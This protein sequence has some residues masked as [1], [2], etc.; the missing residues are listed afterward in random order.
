MDAVM[1]NIHNG[2]NRYHHPTTTPFHFCIWPEQ[3]ARDTLLLVIDESMGRD[4][5]AIEPFELAATS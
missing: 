4:I 5:A 2:H 3:R 1:A